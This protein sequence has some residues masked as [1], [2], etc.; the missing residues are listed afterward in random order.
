MI[1]DRLE[2]STGSIELDK[3]IGAQVKVINLTMQNGLFWK[4]GVDE[5]YTVSDIKFRVSI[6]GKCHT[7]V[8]LD[9]FKDR[10]FTLKDLKFVK[11]SV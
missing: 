9:E 8:Y 7:I 3:L 1:V 6:D 5:I 10:S 4:E 2:G 11:I